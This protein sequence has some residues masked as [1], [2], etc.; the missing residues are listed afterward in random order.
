MIFYTILLSFIGYRDFI[1]DYEIVV[2]KKYTK[3]HMFSVIKIY[4]QYCVSHA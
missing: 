1:S 3:K 2:R 4:G